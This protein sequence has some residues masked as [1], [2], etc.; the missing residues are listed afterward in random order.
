MLNRCTSNP[1]SEKCRSHQLTLLSICFGF[2]FN[3]EL[4]PKAKSEKVTKNKKHKRMPIL[5]ATEQQ[6]REKVL[7]GMTQR[8]LCCVRRDGKQARRQPQLLGQNPNP[9]LHADAEKHSD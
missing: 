4:Q 9:G 6:V 8:R 3:V 5:K 2:V 7:D 1:L